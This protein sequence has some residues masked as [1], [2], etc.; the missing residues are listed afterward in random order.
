M[1]YGYT[2][3][4]IGT[5]L[6]QPPFIAYFALNTRKNANDLIIT[7]NG[8]FQARGFLGTIALPYFA[9]RFGRKWGIALIR[10]LLHITS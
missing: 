1:T 8:V 10:K 3:T 6:G 5:T 2:A 4:I 9:D 7:M